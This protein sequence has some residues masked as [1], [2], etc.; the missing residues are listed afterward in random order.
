[1]SLRSDRCEGGGILFV[2]G[3]R[4]RRFVMLGICRLSLYWGGEVFSQRGLG[5]GGERVR[6]LKERLR[7]VL[8]ASL[9]SLYFYKIK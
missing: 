6:K 7:V 4:R 9:F 8:L 5:F 1:M 2:K 3:L